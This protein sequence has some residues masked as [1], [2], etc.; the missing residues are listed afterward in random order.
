MG[1]G[2]GVIQVLYMYY[3]LADLTGGRAQGVTGVRGSDCKY[4]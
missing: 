4:R 3:A 1:D 2:L